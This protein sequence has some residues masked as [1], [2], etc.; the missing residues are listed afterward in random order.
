MEL[1]KVGKGGLGRGRH[2]G[3]E[4]SRG[5]G[6]R[7]LCITLSS[8]NIEPDCQGRMQ[9]LATT[10]DKADRIT[11]GVTGRASKPGLTFCA[12]PYPQVRY[13]ILDEA[14]QMLDMGF[15]E[16]MET[17][18]SHVPPE[19]QTL[20]FSATMPVWVKKVSVCVAVG[21]GGEHE[22]KAGDTNVIMWCS[23]IVGLFMPLPST[24]IYSLPS[25]PIRSLPSTPICSL[26]SFTA[27]HCR[28]SADPAAAILPP[29][30]TAAGLLLECD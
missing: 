9:A 2:G 16:D 22:A 25:T 28:E 11:W 10:M 17:I 15:E 23:L 18:L 12:L 8:Y 7:F 3:R 13:A 20:L 1:G 19:R 30:A 26:P 6:V 27:C 29:V 4:G 5:R 24:P 14:D 21:V